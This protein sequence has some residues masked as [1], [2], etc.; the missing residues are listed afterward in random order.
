MSTSLKDEQRPRFL[1]DNMLGKLARWLRIMGYDTEYASEVCDSEIARRGIEEGRIILTRD[2]ELSMRRNV[3]SLLIHSIDIDEQL[4]EVKAH[5]ELD[6]REETRCTICNGELRHVSPTEIRG[7]VPA[8]LESRQSDF[9]ICL[10][11]SKIYWPGTHWQN[12]KR[13]IEELRR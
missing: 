9:H 10:R 11:C 5:F 7:L 8:G 4:K 3:R 1:A 2:R 12:I 6:L 13:R